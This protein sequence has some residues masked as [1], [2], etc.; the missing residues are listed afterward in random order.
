MNKCSDHQNVLWLIKFKDSSKPTMVDVCSQ[1][2]ATV[3]Q[4]NE[5]INNSKKSSDININDKSQMK[6]LYFGENIGKVSD[7][8]PNTRLPCNDFDATVV[9]QYNSSNPLHETF[10]N[11]AEY[12]S[13]F[14]SKYGQM[15]EDTV[16]I[17]CNFND[18]SNNLALICVSKIFQFVCRLNGI[19]F[20]YC[21][22]S[23]FLCNNRVF[24]K[25]PFAK[26]TN[27]NKRLNEVAHSTSLNKIEKELGD[28][29]FF[30]LNL[31]N[32][33]NDK[34]D[35]EYSRQVL[36]L[37]FCVGGRPWLVSKSDKYW[38]TIALVYYPS[39]IKLIDMVQSQRLQDIIHLKVES[40]S[41]RYIG[42]S[43]PLYCCESAKRAYI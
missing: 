24:P 38:N 33:T 2:K 41:D 8:Y 13:N 35:K 7:V 28:E 6:I 5:S 3:T 40:L 15:I 25:Y 37:V 18:L 9:T 14:E 36:P 32:I 10:I 26:S 34:K 12:K 19:I 30:M 11:S 20:D 1:F 16:T 4:F 27:V 23:D 22:K 29:P 31:M 43:R 21:I 39:G 42:P 17:E